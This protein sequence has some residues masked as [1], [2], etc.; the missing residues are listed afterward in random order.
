MS[1]EQIQIESPLEVSISTYERSVVQHFSRPGEYVAYPANQAAA[2]GAQ[3]IAAALRAD[4]DVA[5]RVADILMT[6]MDLIYEMRGDLKPAGGA[7]KQEL[8]D[9]HRRTLTKRLEI[10]LNTQRER[11]KVGNHELAKQ[12]V[13]IMMH[14]VFS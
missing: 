2:L 14:E 10:V 11:R 7:M 6:T 4:D 3:M 9:R 13:D 12:V 8:M 1:A 5:P